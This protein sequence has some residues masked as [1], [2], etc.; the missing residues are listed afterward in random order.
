MVTLDNKLLNQLKCFLGFHDFKDTNCVSKR[1]Y[2]SRHGYKK[3]VIQKCSRCCTTTY[4]EEYTGKVIKNAGSCK[5][6]KDNDYG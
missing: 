5:F 3:F 6:I 2:H 1:V 4:G